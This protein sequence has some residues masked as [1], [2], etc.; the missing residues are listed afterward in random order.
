VEGKY[1]S[2]A[3]VVTSDSVYRGERED[4]VTPLVRRFAARTGLELVYVKVVPNDAKEIERAVLDAVERA[5]IVLVTGGT[6]LSPHDKTVDVVGRLASREVPGFGEHHRRLSLERVGLRALLS[7][8]SAFVVKGSFVAVTPGSP[9]AVEVALSIIGGF[10]D[11]LIEQL[12]GK[13]H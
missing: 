5:G 9:D 7:R 10:L 3:V 6:G 12:E 11:H 8:T 1:R 4:R 2:L 13:K